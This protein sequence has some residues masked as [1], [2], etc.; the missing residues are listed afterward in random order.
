MLG[1]AAL[2]AAPAPGGMGAPGIALNEDDS[3]YFFSRAG[4][5]LTTAEVA[6]WVDQYA[7]TQVRELMLCPNAQRTSYDSKVRDPIWRGY[8]PDGPDDQPLLASLPPEGRRSARRWIHTAWQLAHDGIDVYQ[9]WI[10]RARQKQI[11]PWISMRMNDLHNVDDE[12]C[13]IHS[14]FWRAHPQFRRVPYRGSRWIDRALDYSHAEVREHNLALVRELAD[15]YDFDGLELDWM[16][17]GFHF[18]PGHEAEGAEIL[19]RFTRD[20]RGILDQWE[21]RRGHKIRLGARVPSR[22]QTALGLGMDAVRWAS[23]ALIDMLVVTPFWASLEFDMPIEEWKHLLGKSKVTLAAGLEVLIRPYPAL[24]SP[25]L[26]SLETVRGAAS[27]LLDR[28]AERVYLF[29]Y[30]DS[31]TAMEDLSNYQSLLREVGSLG[32]LAGKARRH[33]LTYAD[34]WAPGEP[35]AR[36]GLPAACSPNRWQEFRLP[37]G[38]KPASGTITAALGIEGAADAIGSWELR[39]NG[40]R[41]TF[42]GEVKPARSKPPF[43]LYG[44]RVPFPAMNR[45]YNLIEVRAASGGV[46]HW[47]E[48]MIG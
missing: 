21:K 46:I 14:E 32:T 36:N 38:P 35:E 17:F 11:S 27:S 18:R 41:C 34:T 15:R 8:D 43:P 4:E 6:S 26:N 10:A 7:A 42:A 23:E 3:H 2:S 39:V 1:G 45:G 31:D 33:I 30:M 28:G 44:F 19:T 20:V 9:V 25:I 47:V 22:P 5:K 37:A 29:N 13:F 40:E 24:A 48:L 16:R 12:R